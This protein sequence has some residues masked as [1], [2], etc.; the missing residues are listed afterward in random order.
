[1]KCIIYAKKNPNLSKKPENCPLEKDR[2]SKRTAGVSLQ[3][4]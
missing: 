4:G 1:M 3:S 2:S